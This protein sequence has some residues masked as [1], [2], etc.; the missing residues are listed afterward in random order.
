MSMSLLER[1][2]VKGSGELLAEI[3]QYLGLKSLVNLVCLCK[4]FTSFF[5][6][7]INMLC[8]RVILRNH[9]KKRLT[10]IPIMFEGKKAIVFDKIMAFFPNIDS[11]SIS[12][13][14]RFQDCS[15]SLLCLY[16]NDRLRKTLKHFRV[17]VLS[18]EGLI[19][20]NNLTNLRALEL[21]QSSSAF[22]TAGVK[23]I[24]SMKYLERLNLRCCHNLSKTPM[25]NEIGNLCNLQELSLEHTDINDCH[26][27]L[28]RPLKNLTGH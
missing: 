22:T 17:T 21:P 27:I 14:S 13:N 11:F 26:I 1:L 8:T 19:G 4:D 6:K 12:K 28:F 7:I 16:G 2:G 10:Y 18:D 25:L 24:T 5:V 23:T 3:T 9:E 20:I 15:L